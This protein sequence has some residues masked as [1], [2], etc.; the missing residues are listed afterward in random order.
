M[1][2]NGGFGNPAEQLRSGGEVYEAVFQVTLCRENIGG[3]LAVSSRRRKISSTA[4]TPRAAAPAATG[5]GEAS[6]HRAT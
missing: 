4:S 1:V 6:Q 5:A 3:D 2:G